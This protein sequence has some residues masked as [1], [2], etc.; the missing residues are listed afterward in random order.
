[1][2]PEA[3]RVPE[4]PEGPEP[5]RASLVVC[6]AFGRFVTTVCGYFVLGFNSKKLVESHY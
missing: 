5:A 2:G 1:V 6:E 3:L 4:G